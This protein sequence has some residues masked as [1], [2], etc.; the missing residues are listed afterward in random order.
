VLAIYDSK[1]QAG[2]GQ[3]KADFKDRQRLREPGKP[4]DILLKHTWRIIGRKGYREKT[5]ETVSISSS[6][7]QFLGRKDTRLGQFLHFHD[8]SYY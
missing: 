1:E 6:G 2:Q 7:T 5:A 4:E 3:A 8:G